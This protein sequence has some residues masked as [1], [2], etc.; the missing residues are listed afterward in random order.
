MHVNKTKY[1]Q[2]IQHNITRGERVRK[3]K[4]KISSFQPGVAFQNGFKT[5]TTKTLSQHNLNQSLLL[6]SQP[7]THTTPHKITPTNIK[8]NKTQRKSKNKIN[9]V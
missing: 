6:L 3:G 1:T 2:R 5:L 4:E 7:S 8:Q 9:I